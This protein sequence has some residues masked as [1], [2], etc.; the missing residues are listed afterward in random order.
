MGS[1]SPIG[2]FDSGVGGL[3]ALERIHARMPTVD[4]IYLADQTFTPYGARP[5]SFIVAR[6]RVLTETLAERGCRL[7]VVAYNTATAAAIDTLPTDNPDLVF[8][9]MEPGDQTGCCSHSLER[10]W[11]FGNGGDSVR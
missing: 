3:A 9:G 4:T 8:V 6:A 10:D 2:V 11:R 5:T 7:I 1:A